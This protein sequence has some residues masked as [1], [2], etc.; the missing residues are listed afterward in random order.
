MQHL[1]NCGTAGSCHGGTGSGV[2]NWIKSNPGGIA[3]DTC[4]PYMACSKEST[5]GFCNAT[6]TD[7]TCQPENV[8]R[9][10]ATFGAECVGLEH[11]PNATIDEAGGVQHEAQMMAEIYARGPIA[12]EVLADAGME[13]YQ[14]GI[15]SP[16]GC[17][18]FPNHI[19]SVVGWGVDMVNATPPAHDANS[20]CRAALRD[21]CEAD[22][23]AGV[24]QCVA[25]VSKNDKNLTTAGRCS[26]LLKESYCGNAGVPP[27]P[28]TPP[29]GAHPY[30]IVRNS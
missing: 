6:G 3:F 13:N 10:C 19:V 30:W 2:Y 16:G 11:Y 9:T 26:T 15:Y 5:E 23:A 22:H 28:P 24:S 4:Q 20:T 25:C 27:P 18:G 21:A 17:H 8:C 14:G 1:L 29:P 7:W 12:C